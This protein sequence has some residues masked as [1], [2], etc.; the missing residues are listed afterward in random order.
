MGLFA[1]LQNFISYIATLL[2]AMS[3]ACNLGMFP[4]SLIDTYGT[5]DSIII[6]SVLDFPPAI[7]QALPVCSLHHLLNGIIVMV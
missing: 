4:L 2:N 1:N 6:Q 3:S 5:S 7:Q